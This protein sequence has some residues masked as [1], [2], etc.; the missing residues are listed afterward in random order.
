LQQ[1]VFFGV[2]FSLVLAAVTAFDLIDL[3]GIF[4]FGAFGRFRRGKM[5][6]GLAGNEVQ[7]VLGPARADARS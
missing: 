6:A 3:A 1:R 5:D 7:D 2:Y 4:G